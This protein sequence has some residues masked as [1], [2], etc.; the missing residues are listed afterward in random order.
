MLPSSRPPQPSRHLPL[1]LN[2]IRE[3]LPEQGLHDNLLE[4]LVVHP[5]A[6]YNAH[7]AMWSLISSRRS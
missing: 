3:H 7:A 2:G 6:Y 5:W 4:V 1:R